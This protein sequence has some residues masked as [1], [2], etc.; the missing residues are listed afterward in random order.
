[1][2]KRDLSISPGHSMLINGVLVM[3][4]ALV[5]G[6]TITQDDVPEEI[7][8]YHLEF[9]THD[10]VLAEGAWSESYA[11]TPGLRHQFHN[12]AEF[13]NIYPEYREPE[14][15]TLCAAR[16]GFG[17]VLEAALRQIA[18]RALA[19]VEPGA[20]RGWIDHANAGTLEGWAQDI[21]HPELPVPLEVVIEGRVAGTVLACGYRDDLEKAGLGRG[22]CQ[23]SF[24]LPVKISRKIRRTIRVRR[25]IDGAEIHM[26]EACKTALGIKKPLRM[27]S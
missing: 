3:A 15:E 27:A 1:L 20:L 9:E 25:A 12:V 2:P 13:H 22:R 24:A 6:V 11:D 21:D 8:Y 17:D 5:N 18:S 10:C 23:F 16:A 19:G 26:S 14:M 4:T 7:H